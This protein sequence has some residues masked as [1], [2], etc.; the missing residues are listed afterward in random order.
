[1][2]KALLLVL[3]LTHCESLAGLC[4]SGLPV[5][6]QENGPGNACPSDCGA[7]QLKHERLYVNEF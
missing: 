4:F 2:E 7:E 6:H 3:D 1:M 5:P